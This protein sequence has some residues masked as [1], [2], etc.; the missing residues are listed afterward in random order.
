MT[1][2]IESAKKAATLGLENGLLQLQGRIRYDEP[3]DKKTKIDSEIFKKQLTDGTWD[4]EGIRKKFEL[5][6]VLFSYY[7][8]DP[9]EKVFYNKDPDEIWELLRIGLHYIC[10]YKIGRREKDNPLLAALYT[11]FCITYNCPYKEG[12]LF[13]ITEDILNIFE[14]VLS[15]G[16]KHLKYSFQEKVVDNLI[17]IEQILFSPLCKIIADGKMLPTHIS[18]EK[19][20]NG[21]VSGDA[22]VY[23][24]LAFISH[25][26]K[27]PLELKNIKPPAE[28][29]KSILNKCSS[30]LTQCYSGGENIIS[31][32][33]LAYYHSKKNRMVSVIDNSTNIGLLA[34]RTLLEI[35]TAEPSLLENNDQ[36]TSLFSLFVTRAC[37]VIS[38][39]KI[40]PTYGRDRYSGMSWCTLSEITTI[41]GALDF[42]LDVSDS[43]EKLPSSLKEKSKTVVEAIKNGIGYLVSCQRR[44]HT[45]P[46]VDVDKLKKYT[47][48]TKNHYWSS[49]KAFDARIVEKPEFFNI[50]FS[51][52]LDS[53]RVLIR[54][55]NYLNKEAGNK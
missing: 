4:F 36:S 54:A 48:P 26:C 42:L 20:G 47:S 40:G 35:N 39:K 12:C 8:E 14:I 55:I 29:I 9:W 43:Y 27:N 7:G 22:D 50:S 6:G 21:G 32:S 18:K 17:D 41:I 28:S 2:V 5:Y 19:R 25:L 53:I 51:N 52:T 30:L 44:D 3:K 11:P 46:I 45:W 34:V 23:V 1:D 10:H 38:N 49:V 31:P 16:I 33:Y 15:N 24:T 37:E 13:S